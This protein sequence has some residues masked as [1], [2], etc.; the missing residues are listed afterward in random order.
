VIKKTIHIIL[1]F[2]VFL[3]SGGLLVNFHFCQD[4]FLKTSFF[5]S[6]GSCCDIHEASPCSS[7]NDVCNGHEHSEDD[8]TCCGNYADFYKLDQNQ[9]LFSTESKSFD[10]S[11]FLTAIFSVF[12]AEFPSLDRHTLQY[13]NYSPPLI[14]FDRQ[15]RWQTFLC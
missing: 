9:Q 6:F 15:V 3:S 14:V 8:E 2:S 1:A 10:R 11:G 5:F 7:E 12:D 13:Y 4:E